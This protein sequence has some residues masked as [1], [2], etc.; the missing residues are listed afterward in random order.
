VTTIDQHGDYG[1]PTE[2]RDA[3]IDL[4]V[5]L[6]QVDAE[7]PGEWTAETANA[8]CEDYAR[9]ILELFG[10]THHCGQRLYGVIQVHHCNN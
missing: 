7:T 3:V 9:Y 1:P 5:G 8:R 10:A 2:D 6:A 4:L